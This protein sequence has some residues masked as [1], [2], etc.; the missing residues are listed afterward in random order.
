MIAITMIQPGC[1]RYHTPP[2]SS[3]ASSSELAMTAVPR[4][5]SEI[6]VAQPLALE[7]RRLAPILHLDEQVDAPLAAQ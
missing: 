5:P 4:Q 3:P 7:R 1:R 6:P 2:S